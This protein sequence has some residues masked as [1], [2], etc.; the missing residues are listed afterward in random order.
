MDREP[1]GRKVM[2][3]AEL[4]AMTPQQ[5]QEH[6]EAGIVWDLNELPPEY[7]ARLRADA[8]E[9]IARRDAEQAAARRS[10]PNAS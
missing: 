7:V 2:T 4:E 8:E 3:A 6:F 1:L 10:M 5:R 9:L